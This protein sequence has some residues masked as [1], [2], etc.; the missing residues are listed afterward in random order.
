[1]LKL[2]ICDDNADFVRELQCILQ[3]IHCDEPFSV[4]SLSS[5]HTLRAYIAECG[6]PDI[7]LMDIR[8]GEDDGVNAVN[9]I[10]G[11]ASRTQIIYI[12][13]FIENCSRVYETSHIYFLVKPVTVTDVERALSA[14]VRKQNELRS[15]TLCVK[16]SNE[17]HL[18]SIPEIMYIESYL[19][20]VTIHTVSGNYETYEKLSA[21]ETLCGGSMIRCHQSYCVNPLFV[22][23]LRHGS[24][25]MK[26]N[27]AVP[28]SRHRSNAARSQF[29]EWARVHV[30][31][32][33]CS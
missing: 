30:Q 25:E 20:K 4:T 18:I 1:M 33:S 7:L 10:F 21:L 23:S 2:V 6:K 15:Q 13:G 19:R 8:L 24:F 12:T 16:T 28:I 14:A 17:V 5:L 22:K 11:A 26:N 32:G 3:D 9:E 31:E 27:A 29:L